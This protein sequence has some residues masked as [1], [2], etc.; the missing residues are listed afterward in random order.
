MALNDLSFKLYTDAGLTTPFSG[1]YQLLHQ[2]DLSDNPQDFQLWFGSTNTLNQVQATSDPGVDQ[3]TLTPT[4]TLAEWDTATV[5]ATGYLIQPT[6]PN[7]L[8]YRATVGGTS[9]AT[10]EPTWPTVGIGSTVTDGTVTWALVGAHH[11]ITELKLALT[12]GGLPGATGG[13]ALNLGTTIEGGVAEAVEVNLRVTN[14][15]TTVGSNT[16]Y[17]EIGVFVNNITETEI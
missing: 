10:T 8:K 16:G 5:Y 12:A 7:G 1:L 17:H 11:P 4:D 14:T 6:T 13:A 9:H 2:T 15:V 3:I